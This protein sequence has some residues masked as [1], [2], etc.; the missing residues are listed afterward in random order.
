MIK[1]DGEVGIWSYERH[2]RDPQS[3]SPALCVRHSYMATN[4]DGNVSGASRLFCPKR[5]VEGW[6]VQGEGVVVRGVKRMM[7]AWIEKSHLLILSGAPVPGRLA[8]HKAGWGLRI[9]AAEGRGGRQ[10]ANSA[11]ICFHERGEE[12]SEDAMPER[13]ARQQKGRLKIKLVNILPVSPH[14]AHFSTQRKGGAGERQKTKPKS[15]QLIGRSHVSPPEAHSA[16]TDASCS[17]ISHVA[18]SLSLYSLHICPV[19]PS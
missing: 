16:H 10:L 18:S 2:D 1:G 3:Q 9:M 17:L 19:F 15:L 5:L 8:G 11:P 12:I 4:A 7:M 13:H 6:R 14:D